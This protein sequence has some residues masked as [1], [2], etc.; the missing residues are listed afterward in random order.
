MADNLKQLEW[1]CLRLNISIEEVD[2]YILCHI[3]EFVKLA[4]EW[5]NEH[6]VDL[7]C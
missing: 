4:E 2:V 3:E 1:I 5:R 6:P 7:P